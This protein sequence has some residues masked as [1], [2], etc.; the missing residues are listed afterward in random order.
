M[1]IAPKPL[2]RCLALALFSFTTLCAAQSG[3]PSKP[4]VL[5]A[6]TSPGSDNDIIART[7]A[8]KMGQLIS[9]PVIV[10]N[11]PGAGGRLGV[12][13][14]SRASTDGHTAVITGTGPFILAPLLSRQLQYDMEKS[15]EP[16]SLI[17]TFAS[18][19]VV[20]ADSPYRTLKDFIAAAKAQPGK[21]SFASSGAGTLVHLQGELL[22]IRAGLDL[23]HV[24]YKSQTPALLG[25]AGQESAIMILPSASAQQLIDAGKL[26]ALAV[27]SD[28]R[29]ASLPNVPTMAEAGVADF[30]VKGWYGAYAP[31]GTAKEL[32]RRLS[33]EMSRALQAPEV[34]ARFK[35]LSMEAVGST[36]DELHAIWKADTAVWAKVLEANPQIRID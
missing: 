11:K 2:Q 25:V 36:P 12:A 1:K 28:K 20:S 32:T 3:W 21:L 34:I 27:T 23:L 17:S 31:G 5:V 33:A 30:V 19:V 35:T 9:A 26:R 22:K 8:D 15:L 6:A 18:A 24:P 16:V 7:I 4:I 29:M 10:E 14:T 13:V